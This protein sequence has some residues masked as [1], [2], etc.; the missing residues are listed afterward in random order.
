[1]RF[2][3]SAPGSS[4]NLGPGFDAFALALDIW[5]EITVDTDGVA[6]EITLEGSEA[7]LLDSRENLSITAM[8]ALAKA[9][10]RTLPGFSL[11]ARVD[12]PVARGL[13]SSAAALAVGLAAANELLALGLSLDDLFAFAW[14]ME[15]HGD[16]VGA[17]IYGGAVLAASGVHR[18]V[19]LFN[20]VA[21]RLEAVIFIPEI[22]GATA[23]AR[24]ALPPTVPHPDAAFNVGVA[25][26][27]ALGLHMGDYALVS[28][29]M[30][31]RLHEP[32]R[33]R[34]F[35]HLEPLT[36]AARQA[37]ALGAALSGAG[38]S[39]L[40]LVEPVDSLAVAAALTE[41][42]R[43]LGAPGKVRVLKPALSGLRIEHLTPVA[44]HG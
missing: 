17:A 2:T 21:P 6:G 39:V 37:G 27:L 10:G 40:A 18:P 23:A 31:D 8:Q 5:N 26:G 33:A 7:S 4:A 44:L 43:E 30:R 16:N 28:I 20:G 14:Q 32:Y 24:A 11:S 42:A 41:T 38:P 19:H 13:G 1:M 36:A 34:L 15:G 22:T 12:I 35:P 29:C 25:A 3:I 9:H